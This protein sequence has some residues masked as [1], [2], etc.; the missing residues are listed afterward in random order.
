MDLE[1]RYRKTSTSVLISLFFGEVS[2]T[3]LHC[4]FLSKFLAHVDK[5]YI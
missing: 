1:D 5:F 3:L 2:S 4:F